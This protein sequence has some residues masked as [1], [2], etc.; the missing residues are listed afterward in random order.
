MNKDIL[1]SVAA[2]FLLTSLVGGTC[3][4]A[5]RFCL[6]ADHCEY[7][8][9]HWGCTVNSNIN[10]LIYEQYSSAPVSSGPPGTASFT[11]DAERIITAIGTYHGAG[12]A[13]GTIGLTSE[14]GTA[15]GP[16][17]ASGCS[18]LDGSANAYWVVYP[19]VQL[20]PGTYSIVDSNRSTWSFTPDE[21]TGLNGHCFVFALRETPPNTNHPPIASA[22]G[23]VMD[24]NKSKNID[25]L[26]Q[27]L[28]LDNDTLAVISTST[29]SHGTATIEADGTITYTPTQAYC[30]SDSFTYTI[31]DGQATATATVIISINCAVT[32]INCWTVTVKDIED[33][34]QGLADEAFKPPAAEQK[35]AFTEKLNAVG[36]MIVDKNYPGAMDRLQN[37]VRIRTDGYLGGNPE[38]DLIIESNA[39]TRVGGMIDEL[40][41]NLE[42]QSNPPR[43]YP[44]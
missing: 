21:C 44:G 9:A 24:E 31:S 3:E 10:E 23:L 30:G 29:P 36:G 19:N 42:F 13:P 11:L 20:P 17:L 43:V 5:C 16:W 26:A 40:M 34:I 14:S 38:D 15:Y 7:C 37:D 27:C 2:I 39:Q 8:P 12:D 33:C 28:D 18:G 25:V 6:P 1:A 4:Q 32:S 22:F 41:A 35:S